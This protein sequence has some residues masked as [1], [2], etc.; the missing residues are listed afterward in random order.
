MVNNSLMDAPKNANELNNFRLAGGC[1]CGAIRYEYAG[2]IGTTDLCHCRMCQKAFGNFG[3]VLTRVNLADFSWTRGQPST[4]NSSAI[5]TRGFCS[6]CGTPLYM[7]EQGDRF[8]DLATGTL[9]NP[10]VIKN[11]QS[12]IGIESRVHW[13][14]QLHELPEARTDQT[15]EASELAK[16]SSFQHPDHNT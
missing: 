15:R 12:Q 7:F 16:L 8:L 4:F 2:P 14:S 6:N 1:Q 13:F 11:L 9:D 5:V 10:N 3:A